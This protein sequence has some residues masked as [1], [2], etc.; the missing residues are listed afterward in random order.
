MRRLLR[1]PLLHFLLLGAGLFLVHSL[2]QRPGAAEPGEIVVRRAEIEQ[3]A[4][5]FAKT[6]QRAPTA[7]ELVFLVNDRV[8]EE[9]YG[10]E[11]RA[12]GLDRDDTV[13]R[14]RLRQ[15][16]EF[17][18][19]DIAA[20]AEPSEEELEQHLRAHPEAF[21]SELRLTFLQV[22]LDP[23]RRGAQLAKDVA[24]LLAELQPAGPR[25]DV[26]QLGDSRLLEPRFSGLGRSE[27]ARL[28]GE[29]FAQALAA[30]EPGRWHGPLESGYGVHLVCICEREEGRVPELAEVRAAVRRDWE[31][32]RRAAA[33]DAF[34]AGLLARY[35]VTIELPAAEQEPP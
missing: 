28:F 7:E 17:V 32:A 20:L 27:I 6:W 15:K 8:R 30:L 1:E 29:P 9:I 16:L 22:C 26:A 3:L 33:N 14:R 13:I 23:Q 25:A 34:Y 11:A 24:G 12:L 2:L 19:D 18:T 35:R 5:G 4:A 31:D 10:R 21:R